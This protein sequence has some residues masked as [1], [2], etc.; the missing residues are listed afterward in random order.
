[1]QQRIGCDRQQVRQE[2]GIDLKADIKK[3][4]SFGGFLVTASRRALTHHSMNDANNQR[5][6]DVEA[7]HAGDHRRL[8]ELCQSPLACPLR[9]PT[10][11]RETRESAFGKKVSCHGK[12]VPLAFSPKFISH[13][14]RF[15]YPRFSSASKETGRASNGAPRSSR[16]RSA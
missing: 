7:V 15:S 9:L 1:M 14:K 4:A 8:G 16:H 6:T 2:A 13:P 12:L 10:C 5:N 11:L 3:P